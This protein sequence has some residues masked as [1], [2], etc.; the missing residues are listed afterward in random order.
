MYG[1][2]GSAMLVGGGANNRCTQKK[3]TKTVP[4]WVLFSTH[5]TVPLEVLLWYTTL[6]QTSFWAVLT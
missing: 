1:S 5:E 6:G 2:G 4:P 3:G